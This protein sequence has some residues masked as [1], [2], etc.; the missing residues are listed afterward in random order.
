MRSSTIFLFIFLFKTAIGY[1]QENAAPSIH[2]T[3]DFTSSDAILK[4]QKIKI[5]Q[6]APATYFEVNWF[7]NGYSGLQET[8]SLEFGKKKILISSLWDPNTLGGIRSKVEYHD[9]TTFISRFGG[10]GDGWKTINPYDWSINNWYNVVNRSWK[11][12]GLLYVATFINDLTT[13][14]W[15][16]TATL[17]MPNQ[18]SSYLY[19]QN[20]AFLENWD[21]TNKNYNGSFIR[22]AYFKDCWNLNINGNWEKNISTTFSANN[23]NADIKRNGI[24]HNSFNSFYDS[25]E[26]AYC[27]QHGGN[28]L[29][30]LAFNG[31]RTLN[32]PMQLNQGNLPILTKISI[33]DFSA[34]YNNLN[35]NIEISWKIDNMKSP[36]LSTKIEVIE[37]QTNTIAYQFTDTLPQRRNFKTSLALKKEKYYVKITIVDIF[38]H[39]I[40]QMHNLVNCDNIVKKPTLSSNKITFCPGDSSVITITN[41]NYND[42]IKWYYNTKIDSTNFKIKVFFETGSVFVLRIDSL[43]CSSFSDTLSIVKNSLPAAPIVSNLSYCMGAIASTLSATAIV[44]ATLNWYGTNATGGT[45]SVSAPTPSTTTAGTFNYYVSQITT[46]T[47]CES[48]RSSLVIRVFN[49]PIAPVLSRDVNNF[50]VSNANGITWFKDGSQLPDTSQKIK[51]SIAGLYTAK[52]TQNGC[53]STLSAPYYYLVTDIINLSADEFIQLAPNPFTNKLNFDFVINGYQKLNIE[54][55]DIATGFRKSSTHNLNSGIQLYLGQLSAGTYILR[56]SSNDGK[57]NYQFKMIKL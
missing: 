29:P 10:E 15:F 30:S 56:V 26:N 21:G 25:T 17:S 2:L 39:Q 13:N 37:S 49:T 27:M 43:N 40:T 7:N 34:I 8:P 38:N 36:Q 14:K 9:S 22:K 35:N 33:T 32:L 11:S 31:T 3:Y 20:D 18:N 1:S 19:S 54:V 50:L 41:I 53:S 16:H 52:T 5:I 24:Y 55:F 51:P 46:A 42:K 28:T 48:P 45:A 12:N 47:G 4:M 6:S 23:S 57:I 44:G